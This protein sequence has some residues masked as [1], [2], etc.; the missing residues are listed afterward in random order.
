MSVDQLLIKP[1]DSKYL[2]PSFCN[3]IETMLP[4]LRAAPDNR[5]VDIPPAVAV[6]HRGDYYGLL[7]ELNV[8]VSM[9]FIVLRVN[10][11]FSPHDYAADVFTVTVPSTSLVSRIASTWKESF[12]KLVSI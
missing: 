7:G 11:Y 4:T 1:S 10:G 2:D 9:H 8:D 12:G 6:R 5:H 3:I